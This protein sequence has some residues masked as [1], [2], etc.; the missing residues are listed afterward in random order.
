MPS[1]SRSLEKALHQALA[2]ANERHLINQLLEDY[3]PLERPVNHENDTLNVTFGIILQQIIDVDEKNQILISNLWLKVVSFLVD[4]GTVS[5]TLPPAH[6]H[7]HAAEN[8]P[9]ARVG[10]HSFERETGQIL[11]GGRSRIL[12]LFQCQQAAGRLSRIL[13]QAFQVAHRRAQGIP[14]DRR[15]A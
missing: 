12:R 13:L 2:L 8:L 4:S 15:G 11:C 9:A 10:R 14:Q 3:N 7:F 1:F 6:Q 5:G